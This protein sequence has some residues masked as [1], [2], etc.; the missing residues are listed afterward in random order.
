MGR[1]DNCKS[2]F[3]LWTEEAQYWIPGLKVRNTFKLASLK[4]WSF[5]EG[6]IA[7]FLLQEG[8]L[9][10]QDAPA[11]DGNRKLRYDVQSGLFLL[12]TSS[13]ARIRCDMDFKFYPQIY[14]EWKDEH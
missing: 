1:K 12:T 14:H 6:F 3:V 10:D 13:Y 5:C 8:F 4:N 9:A 2:G 11:T 7:L